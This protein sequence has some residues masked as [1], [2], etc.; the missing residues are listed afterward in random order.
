MSSKTVTTPNTGSSAGSSSS[1][2][3]STGTTK[4]YA[5]KT[6]IIMKS[7]IILCQHGFLGNENTML[8]LFENIKKNPFARDFH[9]VFCDNVLRYT[10]LSPSNKAIQEIKTKLEERPESYVFIRTLFSN[11][12]HGWVT[13]QAC[14]LRDMIYQIKAACPNLPIILVGYSKGGVVNCK[15]AI[16]NP[17]LVDKIV[18]IATPHD[19]TLVQSIV[20][21]LIEGV[22]ERYDDFTLIPDPLIKLATKVL[23]DISNEAVDRLLNG[24]VTYNDLKKEWNKMSVRP[25][26]TPIAGEA[27]IV[28][29]DFK[30]DYVVPTES[31]IASGFYG[32]T[33]LAN[34]NSFIVDDCRVKIDTKLLRKA[35]GNSAELLDKLGVVSQVT[36]GVDIVTVLEVIID[37]LT[38]AIFKLSQ[39]KESRKLAHTRMGIDDFILT[40]PTIGYRVLSGI[41]A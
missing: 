8:P 22:M 30:G 12:T 17:L 31:A 14:E 32:R 3:S 40:H 38:N 20:K 5:N 21:M 10:E 9:C 34:I 37:V 29:D 13:T 18:N 6:D 35:M 16:D 11:P 41:N 28:G 33:H 7:S 26:F 1:G 15:C 39:L 27:V 24:W 2:T 19:D 36:T 23:I 25:K 4:Y